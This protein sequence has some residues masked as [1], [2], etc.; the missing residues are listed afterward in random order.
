MSAAKTMTRWIT[1]K[2]RR[3]LFLLDGVEPAKAFGATGKDSLQKEQRPV[4]MS[5]A[6]QR[7]Q[8]I[9]A[10]MEEVSTND[11]SLPKPLKAAIPGFGSAGDSSLF[12]G[13]ASDTCHG[14][15]RLFNPEIVWV[16]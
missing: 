14:M 12:G 2:I 13:S 6:P 4:D 10:M 8:V 1:I 9:W 15:T 11:S 7:G 5:N 3:N 16:R